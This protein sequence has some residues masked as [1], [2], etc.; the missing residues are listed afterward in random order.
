MTV[1][2]TPS[3]PMPG[4]LTPDTQGAVY[5][6]NEK[7]IV[8]VDIQTGTGPVTL[9]AGTQEIFRFQPSSALSFAKVM[10]VVVHLNAEKLG[11]TP[12]LLY[13]LWNPSNRTWISIEP[14]WT[15]TDVLYPGDY[16]LP[17]GDVYLSVRNLG[18]APFKLNNLSITVVIEALDGN[19]MQFGTK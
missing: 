3:T 18:S 10:D 1:T 16:V 13:E 12:P 19:L 4:T 7:N 14:G 17:E 6:P 11:I 2:S 15:D 9:S 8:I 5:Y